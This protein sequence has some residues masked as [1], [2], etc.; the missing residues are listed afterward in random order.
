[1]ASQTLTAVVLPAGRTAGGNLRANIYLAPRLSGAAH[2]SSF[3]DWLDWPGLIRGNGLAFELQCGANTAAVPATPGPLRPD[4]WHA[5]FTPE[6]VVNPYP[7]PGFSQRLIVSYPAADALAFV[8]YAYLSTATQ[9]ASTRVLQD[10]LEPLRFRDGRESTL[11]AVLGELRVTM[12]Q[13]QHDDLQ[14]PDPGAVT[15]APALAAPAAQAPLQLTQPADT[16]Q[17]A[18]QFAL[19]HR[20]PPAPGLRLPKSPADFAKLFDFHTAMSSLAAHPELLT[21]L[22]LVLPVELPPGF[23][24]PSPGAGGYLNLAV[25]AVNPGWDWSEAPELGSVAT[26]YV[27]DSSSFAA[28]PATQPASVQSGDIVPG[29]IIDGF[30]ALTPG[31]FQLIDVDVD[32]ALLKAMT[33]ADNMAYVSNEALIEPVLPALRSA[34]I[35]LIA[36]AR[37]EQVQQAIQANESLETVLSGEGPGMLSAR[38][39]VR[40]Y[41]LDI[42]SARAGRWLSLHRRDGTYRFGPDGA[43]SLELTDQEGFTQ[44]AVVQP[45]DDPTRPTD[46]VSVG[47]GIPQPGTDLYVNERIAR[48]NGWSLSA[49]RPGTP[50]NR[51]PDPSLAADP[52]PTTG[53]PV[54]PFKMTSEFAA[55]PGSLPQLRYGD[56][57]QMRARAVDLAGYSAGLEAS[58]GQFVAPAAGTALPYLRY[59]PVNAPV[60]VE[61]ITPGPGGSHVELVIRSWN[62]AP[63]LD[64][65]PTT[66]VD[67]R[68]IAPPKASVLL[69]EHHGMLDDAAGRLRSDAATYAM[70]V[71]RDRGQFPTVDNVPI[72]PGEQLVVPYFPDPLARGAAFADLPHTPA[73]TDGT[74]SHGVLSY[75]APPDVLPLPGSVTRVSFGADWPQRQPFRIRLAEGSGLPSWDDGQRV[76]TVPVAKA[77]SATVGLSCYVDPADLELLGVWGWIR[78]LYETSQASALEQ[79]DAGSD[80]VDLASQLALLT[81]LVLGGGDEMITPQLDVTLVHATQ[82]PLGL[83]EWILLPVVHH[84]EAPVAVPSA[85]NAFWRLT[86]WRYI[87]AHTVV[88]LGALRIN[89][90][91]SAAI[92]VHATWTEW[93]DD[94][95]LPGPTRSPAASAVDRIPLGSLDAAPIFSDGSGDRMVAVYLPEVDTLWFAAPFDQLAGVTPPSDVAAPVHDLGDT[96]HRCINYRATASSRFR[97]YFTEPGLVFTRTSDPIMVDVPS[98]V[99]PLAPDVLYVVPTFGW[100]RQESTN[101]KTAVRFGNG[102]RVYLNRP[103]YSSGEGELLGVVLWP[104]SQPAPDDSQR[105][106]YKEFITQWGLDPTWQS[107][108]LSAAPTV[109]DLTTAARSAPA[110][111]LDETSQPVDVAGHTVAFDPDRKLWYCDIVFSNPDAYGPFVRLAL[112][113]YQ[114]SSITGVELSHVVLADFAQLAPDRSASLSLDPATPARARLVVGGP[115]PSGPVESTV[116]VAVEARMPG[117]DSDLGWTPAQPA[118]VS[119]TEDSPAPSQPASVLWSGTIT[120]GSEP[121]PGEFRIVVREYE[122]IEVDPP[123]GSDAAKYGQRLVYASIL[124]FDFPQ[125][126]PA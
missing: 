95:A 77:E 115:A 84:P 100:E 119:V 13:A 116:T 51:S 126:G 25:T 27:R 125:K 72:E 15:A 106:T 29:D 110:L 10:L 50:L 104:A 56:R 73:N 70:I 63:A 11:D 36:N 111:T 54:T 89:G 61:R 42:W 60:V 48:W 91:S 80:L 114:P 9:D 65:V 101:L 71:E 92:D 39:L 24:P 75:R 108:S 76:L 58:A 86:A 102:L 31:S 74:V 32:G 17:M 5:I 66:Q 28:A 97:E 47:A 62:S 53:E 43:V 52:D 93:L 83:P 109:D 121:A 82:Q 6:T 35:S 90:A 8:K 20:L 105:E 22:G 23:C 96:R 78:E 30:L 94:P 44:L 2:L 124:P 38:D 57:Y 33:L 26:Y 69:T 40:G 34:G 88:L 19:Y 123:T 117:V 99:R 79:G 120:F 21:A 98:S 68:H 122:V 45:A 1:M 87:G 12:W 49:P 103:W 67:E 59:D 4:I 113:R 107:G 118:D 85:E 41:R 37:W 7:Q 64:H 3:P 18:E 55:H 16:R 81:R 112:A 14:R 46:P